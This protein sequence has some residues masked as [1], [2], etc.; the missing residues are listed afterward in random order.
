MTTYPKWSTPN[1]RALL[2]K[3]FLDSRGFCVA[4]HQNC[5]IPEH[6]YEVYIERVIDDWKEE[7]KEDWK[8]ERKA[9]HS[10]G[11]RRYPIRGRFSTISKDIFFEK[12]PLYYLEALGMSGLTLQPFAKVKI[13]SS[14]F[15]L[16]IDLGD[17]LKATSKNKRRKAIR[18][19]K[20]LP[21]EVE[22]RVTELVT[23]AVKD[24]LNH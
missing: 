16:Y 21:L 23:L 20:P 2:V 9:I 18:Y 7:D 17:S 14:Y 10:L 8:A 4:G 6:H 3:L 15:R 12:Q 13:A 5:P 19:G 11:E 22:A 1:R 24:Y